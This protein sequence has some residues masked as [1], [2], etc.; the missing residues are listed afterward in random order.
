MRPEPDMI[1]VAD[2]ETKSVLKK[3]FHA[4]PEALAW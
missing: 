2:N 1:S 4:V 3:L